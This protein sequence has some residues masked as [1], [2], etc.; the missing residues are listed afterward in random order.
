MSIS[1]IR[2]NYENL[3]N[4]WENFKKDNNERLEK[5][6]KKSVIDPLTEVKLSKINDALDEQK[7][8]L[9]KLEASI[10]RPSI[11]NNN[12]YESKSQ[13]SIEYKTA[14]MDYI[15]R[16]SDSNLANYE[17]KNLV[18]INT[19]DSNGG[20]LL[21][22]NIQKIITDRLL[23]SCIMRKI[24][25]TQEISTSSLDVIDNTKFSTSWISETG[26]VD[27]TDAGTLNKKTIQ[28][29]DLVAQPK[30]TQKLLDDSAIDF[31]EWLADQLAQDFM[32]A[33]EEAFIKGTGATSNKP[34]G[35]LNYT[36]GTTSSTIERITST[37][38]TDYFTENDVIK[39]FYSLKDEYAKKASFLM[40]RNTVQKVRLLKDSTSGA[41]L[42]NPALLGSTNDTILGCPV[43]QS[44]FLDSVA[45]SKE[46]M[47]FGNFKFYQI[48]DRIGI[49][50]L[51]DPYTSKP[52]IRFY[53]TKR[54]GGDVTKTEAFKVL[55]TSTYTEK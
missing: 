51:R 20:Y 3:L 8:K 7:E 6:E 10:N 43:Y 21:L 26:S 16:G 44:D 22:P 45:T 27:D 13:T 41:Y 50:I 38:T 46:V 49:K 23:D 9:N 30:V 48:V 39:L 34:T 12:S 4:I 35:I 2:K 31:E 54:V 28:T 15:K 18:T 42:W 33:E 5:I 36:N 24:C 52:F 53:T 25:S 29:F 32:K 1:E 47:I 40:S 37:S 14:F 17:K 55:K 19:S 11:S